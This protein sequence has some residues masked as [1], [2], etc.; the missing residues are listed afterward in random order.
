MNHFQGRVI[1]FLDEHNLKG[2]ASVYLHDLSAEF[3][4]VSKEYLIQ[5]RYGELEFKLSDKWKEEL[6]D[7]FFSL[8]ALAACTDVDLEESLDIALAKYSE[9][10]S[11]KGSVGSL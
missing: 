3:G 4:E 7:L 2:N 9:R 8:I 11:S 6:G 10:F 5:T 1:K